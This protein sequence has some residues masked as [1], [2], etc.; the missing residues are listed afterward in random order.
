MTT[1][2]TALKE[3]R[4]DILKG[5]RATEQVEVQL[6]L[7][8]GLISACKMHPCIFLC[9]AGMPVIDAALM[10]AMSS[11]TAR[12]NVQKAFQ[13]LL[14][15]ALQIRGDGDVVDETASHSDRMSA[16]LEKYIDLAAGENGS[17][18][19]NFVTRTLAKIESVDEQ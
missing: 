4:S 15:V 19:I 18:M 1:T 7:A 3:L 10:L 6:A 13:V 17:I 12:P 5:T 8:R 9:K 11:S 2:T 14:W 16:G